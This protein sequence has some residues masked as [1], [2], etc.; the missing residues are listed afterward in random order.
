MLEWL[1]IMSRSY[2]YKIR[3]LF[4]I[5]SL[6]LYSPSVE[7]HHQSFF[8][9]AFLSV[10]EFSMVFISSLPTPEIEARV[11]R[12]GIKTTLVSNPSK[13]YE[14]LQADVYP[15][16]EGSD[17][18]RLIYFYTLMQFCAAQIEGDKI[19]PDVHVRALK[20]LKSAAPGKL[21]IWSCS[22]YF[23]IIETF[24]HSKFCS[25]I[26]MVTGIG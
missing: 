12:L 14:R 22:M 26:T 18:S 1:K 5:H 10:I 23:E 24:I 20:K 17:H 6:Y 25:K 4:S 2:R 9:K 7:M 16:I 13:F 8:G 21:K 11:N 19:K 15:T 3:H